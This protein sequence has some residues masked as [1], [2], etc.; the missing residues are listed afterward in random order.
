MAHSGK[1]KEVYM[2]ASFSGSTRELGVYI[3]LKTYISLF[4]NSRA[5]PYLAIYMPGQPVSYNTLGLTSATP[6]VAEIAVQLYGLADFLPFL[7]WCS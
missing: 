3:P 6:G 7:G 4:H 5:H 1:I 2:C